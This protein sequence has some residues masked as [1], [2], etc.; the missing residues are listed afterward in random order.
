M[1]TISTILG[2]ISICTAYIDDTVGMDSPYPADSR[3]NTSH[4]DRSLV[5]Q[6][7]KARLFL[8]STTLSSEMLD[9]SSEDEQNSDPDL[10]KS[11]SDNS[12]P[13]ACKE[14]TTPY[15]L[16]A[17]IFTPEEDKLL[18]ARYLLFGST[19]SYKTLQETMPIF[20][21]VKQL[22]SYCENHIAPNLRW[23]AP[24]TPYM[25]MVVDEWFKRKSVICSEIQYF[26]RR[27]GSGVVNELFSK[28]CAFYESKNIPLLEQEKQRLLQ[29][30][31]RW[32][33]EGWR[34][35]KKK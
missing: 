9:F 30:Y 8:E 3:N 20:H 6:P 12:N 7:N 16:P 22:A 11:Q 17:S 10:D 27:A 26:V 13:F 31:K 29:T 14:Q 19:N 32:S 1:K 5:R 18:R 25:L 33:N 24:M 34:A 4:L 2:V 35:K 23:N 28:A 15:G 21:T